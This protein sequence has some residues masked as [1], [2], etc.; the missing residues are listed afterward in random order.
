VK[1]H[2]VP[3]GCGYLAGPFGLYLAHDVCQ[4]ET[5]VRVLAGS[6]ADHF[7]GLD[8]GHRRPAQEGDQLAD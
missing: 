3:T 8:V 7:D 6:L 4:V 1:K 5:T 2:V